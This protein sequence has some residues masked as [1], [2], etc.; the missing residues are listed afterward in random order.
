[1][2]DEEE[3]PGGG[4]VSSPPYNMAGLH[5]E[6]QYLDNIPKAIIFTNL[7]T[8]IFDKTEPNAVKVSRC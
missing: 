5:Q 7:P 1:M 8:V 2:D 3:H 6:L 4:A